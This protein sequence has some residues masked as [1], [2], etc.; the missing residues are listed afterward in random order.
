MVSFGDGV[1][2]CG[3]E[4]ALSLNRERFSIYVSG[5]PE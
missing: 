2:P 5:M 1:E 4:A 3:V